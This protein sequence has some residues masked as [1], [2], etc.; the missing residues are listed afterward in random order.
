[1]NG[2]GRPD[3]IVGARAADPSDLPGAGTATV[4]SGLDGS[5]LQKLAGDSAGD[6]FGVSVAGIG[7]VDGDGFDDVAVGAS[8]DDTTTVATD[9]VGSVR[10]FSGADGDQL[11]RILGPQA[12]AAL[13]TVAPAGDWNA[14]GVPDLVVGAPLADV[15]VGITTI[16]NAGQAGVYSGADGSLIHM[17]DG[18]LANQQFGVSVDGGADIDGD[19]RGDIVAGAPFT[20]VVLT[21]AGRVQ[22]FSNKTRALLFTVEGTEAL[23]NLGANVAMAGD[24]NGDGLQDLIAGSAGD[25]AGSGTARVYLG[26]DGT[27]GM[28]IKGSSPSDHLGLAVD[29]AGDVDRDGFGD[30]V[31]GATQVPGGSGYA[32]VVSGR[33]EEILYGVINGQAVGDQFGNA[34][35]G[36]GDV[37]GDG[38]ADIVVSAHQHDTAGNNAGR[39]YVFDV[40]VHQT[41]VGFGESGPHLDVYGTPLATGGSADLLLAGAVPGKPAALVVSPFLGPLPFKGGILAPSLGSALIFHLATS[42]GGSVTLPSIPGGGGSFNLYAQFLVHDLV[43]DPL[44][45]AFSNCVQ[46]TFLP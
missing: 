26:P 23:G 7:D 9:N 41:N 43:T 10:V 8:F 29:G 11:F 15:T 25:T 45:W 12:G 28:V 31:V 32:L 20:S 46:L 2:D 21:G 1:V 30:L 13:G 6:A 35:A 4:F 44:G 17:F 3:I 39:T 36:I 27:P 14:D 24:V 37:N 18:T 16:F 42:A 33:T 22:V 40:L 38:W 34:V 19:G 5:I